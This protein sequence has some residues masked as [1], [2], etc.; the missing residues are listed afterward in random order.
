MIKEYINKLIQH[1]LR[2]HFPE[3]DFSTSYRFPLSRFFEKNIDSYQKSTEKLKKDIQ[4]L[5]ECIVSISNSQITRYDKHVTGEIEKIKSEISDLKRIINSI[6]YVKPIN[7]KS[8]SIHNEVKAI[9]NQIKKNNIDNSYRFLNY[10]N[11]KAT[12][13]KNK[14]IESLIGVKNLSSSKKL[15]DASKILNLSPRTIRDYITLRKQGKNLPFENKLSPAHVEIAKRIIKENPNLTLTK[16]FELTKTTWEAEGL[17][18]IHRNTLY[19]SSSNDICKEKIVKL[20]KNY[21]GK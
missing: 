11:R 4:E 9:K 8:V 21:T 7:K 16:V 1:K 17:N 13:R 12:D 6:N 18:T 3:L 14:I 2:Y 15:K 5:K 20:F 10:R 19:R